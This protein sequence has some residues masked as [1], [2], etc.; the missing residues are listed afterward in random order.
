MPLALP[1][2]AAHP[3][4]GFPY[5]LT[6][7]DDGTISGTI[8]GVPVTGTYTGTTSG[9]FV[10]MV[11]AGIPAAYALQSATLHAADV[12]GASDQGVIEVGKRA[13]IV[14]MPGDPLSDITATQRVDFVMKDGKVYRRPGQEP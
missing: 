13:D 11:E 1:G 14:A 7:A 3:V 5:E 9:E 8:G 4:A 10:L 6:F 12:L 2:T